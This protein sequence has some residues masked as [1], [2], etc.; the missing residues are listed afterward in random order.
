MRKGRRVRGTQ[1]LCDS[2]NRFSLVSDVLMEEG[3]CSFIG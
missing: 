3:I 2:C 1:V